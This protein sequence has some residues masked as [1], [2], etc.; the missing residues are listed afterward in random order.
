LPSAPSPTLER[1][2]KQGVLLSVAEQGLAGLSAEAICARAGVS[3][4][5]LRARWP[6]GW[7]VLIEAI[8]ERARLPELPDTGNLIDDLVVYERDYARYCGDPAL[9]KVLFFFFAAATSNPEVRARLGPGFAE[10]RRRNLVLIERAVARGELPPDADGNAILDAML[11]LSLAWGATGGAPP[12]PEIRCAVERAIAE[13]FAGRA[14]RAPPPKLGPQGAYRLYLFET[15]PT[16]R[17]GRVAEVA[18]LEGPTE[19]DAVA[20]ANARRGGRYAELWRE[21]QLVRIFDEGD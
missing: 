8:D 14:Q 1:R 18:G 15:S 13:P 17:R 3:E 20:E 5:Q 12:E 11:S 10:R 4:A 19:D 2:I 9:V 6:D 7:A 16:D 21:R